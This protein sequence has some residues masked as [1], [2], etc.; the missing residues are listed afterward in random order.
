MDAEFL[1]IEANAFPEVS[2]IH[3]SPQLRS[4]ARRGLLLA[5]MIS[6]LGACGMIPSEP[7]KF[8]ETYVLQAASLDLSAVDLAP[9]EVGVNA[10][11]SAFL[12]V[13]DSILLEPTL[14]QLCSACVAL[15][16]TTAAKPAFTVTISG[17]IPVSPQLLAASIAG[18]T[19]DLALGNGLNFDPIRPSATARGSI[20]MTVRRGSTTIA[21]S[22]IDGT[23]QAFGPGAVIAGQIPVSPFNL[24]GP[25]TVDL[26]VT[27][28][29]GDAVAINTALQLFAAFGPVRASISSVTVSVA[30]QSFSTTSVLDLTETKLNLSDKLEGGAFRFNFTNPFGVSGNFSLQIRQGSTLLI[31]KSITLAQTATSSNRIGLSKSEITSLLGKSLTV[32]ISGSFNAPSGQL[33]LTP[34]QVAN[35]TSLLEIIVFPL[36]D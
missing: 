25:L 19:I 8:E 13:S 29:A 32:T 14:G 12:I 27:S 17:T 24:N 5:L 30:S 15:N 7:P 28:P 11:S 26:T 4:A 16:G 33:T 23:T 18:G 36:G 1:S 9:A 10:D 20:V 35:F 2:M 21:T 22:G 31:D 34:K 6:T 3:P